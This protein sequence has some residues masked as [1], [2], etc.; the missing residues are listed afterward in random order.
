MYHCH[1][2]LDLISLIFLTLPWSHSVFQRHVLYS[3]LGPLYQPNWRWAIETRSPVASSHGL[4]PWRNSEH[5]SGML[6]AWLSLCASSSSKF[7]Q[8]THKTLTPSNQLTMFTHC[9]S[10]GIKYP[11]S[12]LAHEDGISTQH[13]WDYL[14]LHHQE[15]LHVTSGVAGHWLYLYRQ[16]APSPA[17]ACTTEASVGTVRLLNHSAHRP[18][19]MTETEN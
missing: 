18:L 6:A 12:Q 19:M 16:N 4:T 15:S 1:E 11:L 9:F 17:P 5:T 2:L 3:V 10:N 7:D 8:R 14:C 13:F